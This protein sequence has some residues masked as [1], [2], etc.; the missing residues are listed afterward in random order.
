[1]K[2]AVWLEK[3][4]KSLALQHYVNRLKCR[5]QRC[6]DV[7][8]KLDS[9]EYR[10]KMQKQRKRDRSGHWIAATVLP[11]LRSRIRETRNFLLQWDPPHVM[12]DNW[13]TAPVVNDKLK[14]RHGGKRLTIPE[15]REDWLD[16]QPGMSILNRKDDYL[17]V[18]T[19]ERKRRDGYLRICCSHRGVDRQ[20]KDPHPIPENRREDHSED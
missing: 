20:W 13:T 8:A 7:N 18:V 2:T 19:L 17:D 10:S 4:R 12:V 11:V 1:M 9:S 14:S 16:G 3:S 5:Y 15:E 6:E